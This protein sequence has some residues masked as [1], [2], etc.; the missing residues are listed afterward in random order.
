MCRPYGTRDSLGGVARHYRA[1][2]QIV[3]S[4]RDSGMF[5]STPL[6]Y[7]SDRRVLWLLISLR[8]YFLPDISLV[9]HPGANRSRM[10]AFR[11]RQ[12]M[13]RVAIVG[14]LVA[15]VGL[16]C[17]QR[18]WGLDAGLDARQY[19]HT[20]WKIR[21]GF[22]KGTISSIAQTPDG[23]LWLGTEFG[24]YRF[25][26]VRA[27][28]WHPPAGQQ[29]PSNNIRRLLVSRDGTLWIGSIKGLAGWKDGKLTQ[30][31]ELG[32]QAI[33]ALL[34]D[35][36]GMVWVGTSES[37]PP[38]R[39]CAIRGGT[40]QCYGEDGSIGAVVELF[41]DSKGS[42]WV[43]ARDGLWH[44]KPSRPQLYRP[45]GGPN[46]IHGLAEDADGA[47]LIG[48]NGGIW[49]FVEGK[50]EAYPFTRTLKTLHP[51]K[52]LRD[53]DGGL[54]ITTA[55]RG[56]VHVH[57]GRTDVFA[58]PDG[59]SSK[60]S[61]AV[62]EDR[63]GNIWTATY[64]GLD[65]F[66]G[67]AVATF[68]EKQGLPATYV[69][70]VLADKDGSVWV[71]ASTPGGLYRG[72]NSEF[73]T[74]DRR[75]GKLNGFDAMSLFQDARG[76]VWVSTHAMHG[77]V[78]HL[79]NNRFIPSGIPGRAV[80]SFAEDRAG[81]LW[82]ADQDTGL[83]RLSAENE[84]KRIPWTD[85]GH[86]DGGLALAAD[87]LQGGLWIGFYQGG[88]IYYADGKIQKSYTAADGLGGGRIYNLRFGS[89]GTLWAAMDG[90]LSRIRDGRILTLTTKNGLPCDAVHW[91]LEDDD[92][93]VWVYMPCGLV[94]VARSELDAWVSDPKRIV[95]TTVF[96]STDGVR[97]RASIGGFTPF[98]SKAP[99]GKLWFAGFDGVS[100]I[101][102]RHLP[103][104]KIPP[105]VYI[106]QVIADRKSYYDAASAATGDAEKRLRLPAL[107]RE[108]QIDYTALSL[109]APEKVLFR[110]KLE[111]F[112]KDWQEAGNRRQA[113]YTNLSPKKY[114]FRLKACNN[115][116]VWNEEG[117]LLE[118]SIAPAYYQTTWF[119]ALCVAAFLALLWAVY[120]YR[121]HQIQREFNAG[122]EGRVNERL[123]IARELHDTLLQSFQGLVL[124]FQTA[125]NLLPASPVEA[126]EKLDNA[127]DIAAQ[128][129]T[130]GRSAVQ[131]LRESATL[132]NELAVA[133]DTLGKELAGNGTNGDAP[134]F[135]VTVEGEPQ[136]LHPILR[137]E[138]YRIAAEAMRNAFRHA[139]ARNIEVE[140]HYD[141]SELRVR[142]RDDG[143]GIARQIIE[144]EG[145]KGHWGLHGMRERAKIIG[146][147]LEVWS[148]AESGTEVELTIPARVAYATAKEG[149]SWFSRKGTVAGDD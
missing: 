126:K 80:F 59:L 33:N 70:S 147:N 58:E 75:D 81:S 86:K 122:L 87:P 118:F 132:K 10:L 103:N 48:W 96:D 113:F 24:L 84:I 31:D 127:I 14:L 67:F 92:H 136:D 125:S 107:S 37:P 143:K 148:S 72:R 85:L 95:Q 117:A 90:G 112:D 123:R 45:T 135:G 49:R 47:L 130:E 102:P 83:F 11:G 71:N 41:E 1:G 124:R 46:F 43:A 121:L 97:S 6:P 9:A 138:V 149:R 12:R 69:A 61:T 32:G 93:F 7:L 82:M 60:T 53:R 99:D 91:S 17:A 20:A 65:R 134:A 63:E 57:Q 3:A 137:D 89:R 111:G 78:G 36:E 42:L 146:G 50:M 28:P 115:S 51:Q 54:W 105:P 25:D 101:D 88:L 13:R 79:E 35:H 52:M 62:F 8:H 98:A 34:E 39:L 64:D 19:A 116:G 18:A 38:G 27:V 131:G 21:D 110:Y 68:G 128:A 94:R 5:I 139:Q 114:T 23:Y 74:Y 40:V 2:L 56:I 109:A 142:V 108:L 144:N 55:D 133:V 145:R 22:T 29:L 106:E 73:T 100:V 66:R 140:I 120:Q 77:E 76:R 129:V 15:G 44:W 141:E 119:R 30:Y 4:L 16:V 26:G 104:N